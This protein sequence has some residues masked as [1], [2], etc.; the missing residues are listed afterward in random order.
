MCHSLCAKVRDNLQELAVG[1]GDPW[2]GNQA[3]KPSIRKP[4]GLEQWVSVQL[5][6]TQTP[7]AL[8][9]VCEAETRPQLHQMSAS[10][11]EPIWALS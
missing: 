2:P 8:T 1:Q 9:N 11:D 6:L 4:G 7:K 3:T 10:P 5:M